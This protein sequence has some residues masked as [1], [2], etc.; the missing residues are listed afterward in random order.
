MIVIMVDKPKKI[1]PIT[2]IFIA[3]LPFLC[4]LYV[5]INFVILRD[6]VIVS[7]VPGQ[8]DTVK[9]VAPNELWSIAR[10]LQ[11]CPPSKTKIYCLYSGSNYPV[12]VGPA[13]YSWEGQVELKGVLWHPDR[14]RFIVVYNWKDAPSDFGWGGLNLRGFQLDRSNSKVHSIPIGYWVKAVLDQAMFGSP[15][16]KQLAKFVSD[17]IRSDGF[18]YEVYDH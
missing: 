15:E 17:W 8:H 6:Q 1:K 2:V 13:N 14:S 16:D 3:W 11:M 7:Y 12:S 18:N 5:L 10:A 9:V 4:A